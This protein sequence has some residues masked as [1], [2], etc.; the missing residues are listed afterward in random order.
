MSL[1]GWRL[2][3]KSMIRASTIRLWLEYLS[4]VSKVR[5]QKD[6]VIMLRHVLLTIPEEEI[7]NDESAA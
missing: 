1:S 5:G 4:T 2:F 6:M 3:W 7:E